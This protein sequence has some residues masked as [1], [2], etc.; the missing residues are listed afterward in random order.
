[1]KSKDSN[2]LNTFKPEF[3]RYCTWHKTF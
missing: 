1:M 2:E 3:K